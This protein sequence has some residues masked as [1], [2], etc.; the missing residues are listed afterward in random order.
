M[1][2]RLL[3]SCVIRIS[4]SKSDN[5]FENVPLNHRGVLINENYISKLILK[6]NYVNI[7]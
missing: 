5:K 3:Q 2:W 6:E 1:K 7:S 4:E